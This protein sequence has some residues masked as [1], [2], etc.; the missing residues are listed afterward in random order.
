VPDYQSALDLVNQAES[1]FMSLPAKIRERF[2]NNPAKMVK[3]LQD[4]KNRD[5]AER[6]GLIAKKE[7]PEAPKEPLA[8]EPKGSEIPPAPK[9]GAEK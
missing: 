4:E 1:M 3:F 5:E 7:L 2:A 9:K 6:L 8:T